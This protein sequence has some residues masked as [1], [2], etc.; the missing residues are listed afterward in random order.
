VTCTTTRASEVPVHERLARDA[1]DIKK[2][3]V[4]RELEKIAQEMEGLTFKPNLP[5]STY[6]YVCTYMHRCR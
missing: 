3:A 4:K 5:V 2:E 1:M 6:I